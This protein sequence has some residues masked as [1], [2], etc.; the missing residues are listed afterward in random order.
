M[1]HDPL[2]SEPPEA[3]VQKR[4]TLSIIWLIPLVA[5]LVGAWLVIK[6]VQEK[7]PEI[8]IT[9]KTAEGL[10]AGKT[11]IRYK[12]VDVGQVTSIDLSE[13]LY[14]VI[15]TAA[16][17]P[18]AASYLT[19]KARFWVVRAR[20]GFGEVSGLGTLFSGAYI[21]MDPGKEGKSTKHFEGME[22]P[23][24]VDVSI[25]GSHFNLRAEH[26]G[27][28]DVGAPV[29]FRRIPVG[30]VENYQLADDGNSIDIGVFV[31]APHDRRVQKNTRFYNAGGV[32]VTVGV[33][34]IQ[35][36]TQALASVLMGGLA[37]ETPT[38]LEPGG[39]VDKNHVFDL[40][41]NRKSINEPRYTRK[42]YYL[43]YFDET[44]RGLAPGAPVE[45]RGIPIGE[46]VDIKLEFDVNQVAARI[47][48]LIEIQPDRLTIV[49]DDNFERKKVGELLVAKGL[50]AQLKTGSLLT[51]KLLINLDF[52]PDAHPAEI[53]FSGRYPVLP[54]VPTPISE[55]TASIT[56]LFD[57]IEALP[58]EEIG[59]KLRAAADGVERLV[60]SGELQEAARALKGTLEGAQEVTQLITSELAPTI[61]NTMIQMTDSL[62]QMEALLRPEAPIQQE[63]LRASTEMAAAARA[64]RQLADYLERHPESLLQGKD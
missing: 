45:F 24:V 19:E 11:K 37:F 15:V 9:F 57:R 2:P 22:A 52:F 48:V 42:N 10:E 21:A 47:P 49:G 36:N 39:T 64:I 3:V 1:S 51:G 53:V 40:Y 12:N 14:H 38:N 33:D 46:V 23:P 58:I 55:I 6:A 62:E 27:S 43:L 16:M 30:R 50:R 60:G 13:D 5:A 63:L 25:P 56:H 35:V 26:L 41:P 61:N 34:G 8:T 7:G 59:G 18:G 29:Y 44:V 17:E 20:L 32:D 54:T 31:E 28:I 4:R